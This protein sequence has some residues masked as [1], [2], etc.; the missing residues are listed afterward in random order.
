MLDPSLTPTRLVDPQ[1]RPKLRILEPARPSRFRNVKVFLGVARLAWTLILLKL[2]RR[3]SAARYG[4]RLRQLIESMGGL[5]FKVGQLLSL[6]VDILP[7]EVCRE[8]GK[9]QFSGIGFPGELARQIVEQELGGPI[10]HFF[11]EFST[12]PFAAASIGQ[13]HRGR[14][15]R[16][17]QWVAVKV[18]RPYV[19]ELF[20]RDLVFIR[21]M[22]RFLRALGVYAHMRWHEFIWELEQMMNEE[23]DYQYE[24]SSMRRMRKRLRRHGVYV[25]KVY[26]DYTKGRLL[27]SEFIH[28]VLMAD[29][30]RLA[31]ADP[32][33]VRS[34]EAA[35]NVDPTRVAKRL[36]HS[37][38]R[39]LFEENLYHGDLHPGN[40][41][42]LRD[43]RVALIDFGATNFTER[44]YLEKF[45]MCVAAL[46]NYDYAKD[47]DLT[48]LLSSALPPIDTEVA[49]EKL[50]RLLRAWSARMHVKALPYHDRSIDNAAV[51]I[52]S[53]TVEYKLTMD[54]A[55]LRIRRAI[56][57][58]DA[59]LVFL[60]PELNYLKITRQYFRRAHAR[61]LRSML[62]GG[63]GARALNSA[64]AAMEAQEQ[65]SEYAAFQTGIIRRQA[66]VF[67]AA[68]SKFSFA[69]SVLIG[70]LSFVVL[71][72]ALL[73]GMTLA[74][75]WYPSAITRMLGTQLGGLVSSLIPELETQPTVALLIIESYAFTRLR[76]LRHWL[77]AKDTRPH[78]KSL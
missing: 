69:V 68:S 73:L 33:L 52:L 46:S 41:V 64:A 44:E 23:L 3:G 40:I 6:R 67:Q 61:R 31:E 4:V 16:E 19:A 75:R 39:Q 29:Y 32:A 27:V 70:W 47:A 7:I 63:L 51:I 55:W 18:Q 11:D 21:W 14:L 74:E 76:A 25:P 34:W 56:G 30:I 71:G 22:T 62:G 37:M 49:K 50:I 54:W 28:A 78:A 35:N 9:L 53:V 8:L 12:A 65:L 45:R 59:S 38:W 43:S 72:H 13:V 20:R 24:A 60:Y 17:G 66:Q 1:T 26:P 5:W 15:R 2:H 48:F 57:T 10:D 77:R 36:I 42:L 58:L